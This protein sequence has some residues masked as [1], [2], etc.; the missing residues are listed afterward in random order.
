MLTSECEIEVQIPIETW[1]FRPTA[2]KWLIFAIWRW[3]LT[4]TYAKCHSL[5]LVVHRYTEMRYW[6]IGPIRLSK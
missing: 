4:R 6:D 1:N 3:H 5:H 2:S